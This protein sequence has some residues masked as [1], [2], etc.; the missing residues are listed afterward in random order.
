MKIA[1]AD[2]QIERRSG[3]TEPVILFK[4]AKQVFA[5]AAHSVH[6]IRSTNSLSGS[7]KELHQSGVSKVRGRLRR[8]ES[9][10]YIVDAS[11]HFGLPPSQPTLVLVLRSSRVAVLA[12][13]IDRMDTIS[14]LLALP[15][16]FRGPEREWY[17]GLAL[18]GEEVVP[19]V[20]S[21]GFLTEREIAH[22]DRVLAEDGLEGP[23]TEVN[24]QPHPEE[25]PGDGTP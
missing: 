9:Y 25:A 5:I 10:H 22:L 24:E 11:E 13:N 15:R 8:D 23:G 19:V 2:R 7:V 18:F 3:R 20:S 4:V 12:D 14:R 6:D 21:S 1:P 17:R 16:A